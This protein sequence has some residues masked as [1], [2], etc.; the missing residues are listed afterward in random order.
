MGFGED[1]ISRIHRPIGLPIGSH[2]PPE[3]AVATLA[4]LIADRNS[5]TLELVT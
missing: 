5:R 2:T 3:I 1:E 4:G